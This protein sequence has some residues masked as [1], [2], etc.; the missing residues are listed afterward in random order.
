MDWPEVIEVALDGIAQGG[1]GVGRWGGRVVFVGGGLPG[2][3][4][5]VRLRERRAAFARGDA[6]DIRDPSPDRV[7]PRLPGAGWMPWQ[8]IAYPAQLRFKRQILADQLAKIGG[9]ADLPVEET[10]LAPRQWGYRS[11]A[12]F[13][14][15]G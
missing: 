12:R 1:E 5:R 14:S 9:L 8:H 13:H 15:D 6:L 4:V 3:Q 11:G 10:L 2:E 7:A